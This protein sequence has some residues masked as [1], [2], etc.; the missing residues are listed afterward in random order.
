MDIQT[1]LAA[2][3]GS[4]A[5]RVI[6]HPIDTITVHKQT[7][8][9]FSF[10]NTPLKAYYRGLPISLT[11]I[12]PATCLYMSTYVES[13]RRLKDYLGDGVLLYSACGMTAEVVSSFVWTPL[14]VIKARTQISQHGVIPTISN[15]RKQEGIKGF[16]RGYWMG[17]AI[18]LPTTVS[19]WVMYEE[20]KKWLRAKTNFDISIVAPLSSALGTVVATTIST[21][22]DIVKTRYQVA[23]SSAM[24]KTEFANISGNKIKISDVARLLFKEHGLKGFTRGLMFRMG[25][26]MPSGMISMSVFESFRGGGVNE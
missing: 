21:P 5:S 15:L 4:V 22:L 3:S 18:Y 16:Y 6:C 17:I 13:K 14:E 24:Q 2:S 10:R 23:T 8:G 26:I 9:S 20:T 19:W 25:Y 12:T 1:L 11:L 7:V